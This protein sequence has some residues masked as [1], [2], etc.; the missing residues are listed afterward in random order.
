MTDDWAGFV[1]SRQ[2]GCRPVRV[3]RTMPS[4]EWEAQ[5]HA[6]EAQHWAR[7]FDEFVRAVPRMH[8]R[9]GERA[10]RLAKDVLAEIK[11]AQGL[12]AAVIARD[13][14]NDVWPG[15]KPRWGV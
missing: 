1:C 15:D 6:N 14:L 12:D 7:C 11:T 8:R 3:P 5:R 2:H 9:R 4:P 13:R 10:G